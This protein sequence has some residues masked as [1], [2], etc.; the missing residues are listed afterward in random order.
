MIEFNNQYQFSDQIHFL[1]CFGFIQNEGNKLSE[2]SETESIEAEL[3]T[4]FNTPLILPYKFEAKDIV[5][6][7]LCAYGIHETKFDFSYKTII[8]E[9][10]IPLTKIVRTKEVMPFLM[11]KKN[12]KTEIGTM[13]L[14]AK[15]I[16]NDNRQQLVTFKPQINLKANVS[17]CFFALSISVSSKSSANILVYKSEVKSGGLQFFFDEIELLATDLND[18]MNHKEKIGKIDLF[19]YS[20]GNHKFLGS[21]IFTVGQINQGNKSI[22]LINNTTPIGFMQFAQFYF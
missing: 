10:S 17:E 9:Y 5:A 14:I 2:R 8:H 11:Y 13:N 21:N 3:T 16:N 19:E 22:E 6:I 18:E 20:K 12:T 4:V 15:T 1:K 7:K